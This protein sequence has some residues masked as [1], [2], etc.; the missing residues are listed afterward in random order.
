[1][2]RRGRAQFF[3]AT[4]VWVTVASGC[5][6]LSSDRYQRI[7]PVEI[8]DA[9]AI[10]STTTT[11][12]LFRPTVP[13]V[14]TQPT[15]TTTTTIAIPTESVQLYF[16]TAESRLRAVQ[17]VKPAGIGVNGIIEELR[18]GPLPSEGAGLRSLVGGG[19]IRAITT[20]PGGLVMELDPVVP[21]LEEVE[22]ALVAAQI[23]ATLDSRPNTAALLFVVNGEPWN[24]PLPEKV[25]LDYAALIVA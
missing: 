25:G 8:Q 24:P 9:F 1:M 12:S 20:G 15:S 14:P 16:I 2:T 23:L 4:M 11:T 22:Q 18:V 3:A 6:R 10:A 13:R 21:L 5:G 7:D 17:R 19:V